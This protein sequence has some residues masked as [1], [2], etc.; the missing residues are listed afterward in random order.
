[1]SGFSLYTMFLNSL[2]L[3]FKKLLM[4]FKFDLL[5]NL[6]LNLKFTLIDKNS[7]FYGWGRKNLAMM[8]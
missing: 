5:K 3:A 8:P 2:N 7:K 1:M 6:P 4:C